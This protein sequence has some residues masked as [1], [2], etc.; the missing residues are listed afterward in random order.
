MTKT[1]QCPDHLKWRT[2]RVDQPGM[3]PFQPEPTQAEPVSTAPTTAPTAAPMAALTV[4]ARRSLRPGRKAVVVFLL[5]MV[6]A[7]GSFGL[8]PGVPAQVGPGTVE[9][10][11]RPALSGLTVLDVPP[12][13]QVTARTH[14]APLQ[15]S[16]RIASVDLPGL[17]RQLTGADP[18]KTLS[19]E[20]A[21]Q[22]DRLLLLLA[23]LLCAGGLSAGLLVGVLVPGRNLRTVAAGVAGAATMLV[24]TL[25]ATASTFDE[26]ALSSPTFHGSLTALPALMSV[27]R[28][29]RVLSTEVTSR[30]QSLTDQI[31][32]AYTA[33]DAVTADRASD[34]TLL[35]VSD[36]GGNPVGVTLTATLARSLKADAVL[37]TGDLTA[38]GTPLEK[39]LVA[40]ISQ[41]RQI[42]GQPYLFVGGDRDS[43][44]VRA[45]LGKLPGVTVLDGQVVTIG[46]GRDAVRL[47]GI[48]DPAFTAGAAQGAAQ[49]RALRKGLADRVALEVRADQP[50]LLVVHDPASADGLDGLVPVVLTGHRQ[51]RTWD[52]RSGTIYAGVG[53][54]GAG[55]LGARAVGDRPGKD[56]GAGSY[57]AELLR[58][59]DGR[60]IA[61]DYIRMPG[62]TGEF[63]VT[64]TMVNHDGVSAMPRD[65]QPREVQPRER[66]TRGPQ[67]RPVASPSPVR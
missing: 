44:G 16:A 9:V 24:G 25:G 1:R 50:G 48:S 33:G 67:A 23:G 60:L 52:D 28:D 7:W 13:G 63:T 26:K 49:T 3:Q 32:Q 17:G 43:P 39:D 10:N 21:G 56:R 14:F 4:P 46:S 47:L 37:D 8:L 20:A 36:I 38:F 6:A 35:H 62:A 40:G 61:V 31:E 54:T 55:G 18:A 58:F 59:R 53:S 15:V 51:E 11:V 12:L 5:G 29:G 30:L 65:A 57:E 42:T 2:Q 27:T 34:V 41:I 19:D 22:V 45:R 64:R 66:A